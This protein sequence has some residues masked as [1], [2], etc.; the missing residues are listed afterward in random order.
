MF[1]TGM[2]LQRY[3]TTTGKVTTV[4]QLNAGTIPEAQISADGGWILFVNRM[5]DQ[6]RLKILCPVGA[7]CSVCQPCPSMRT[8]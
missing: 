5:G 6:E 2:K 1:S 3:D 7:Q 4:I 8:I